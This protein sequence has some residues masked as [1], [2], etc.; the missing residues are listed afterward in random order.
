MYSYSH[1][2]ID[3]HDD[4]LIFMTLK[5]YFDNAFDVTLQSTSLLH[6]HHLSLLKYK[7]NSIFL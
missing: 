7:M 5:Y 1:S 2:G 4:S 3:D 6:P